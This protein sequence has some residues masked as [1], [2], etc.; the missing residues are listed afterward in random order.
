MSHIIPIWMEIEEERN[1]ELT[2]FKLYI[3]MG[4]NFHNISSVQYT[5]IV[6]DIII[7]DIITYGVSLSDISIYR[8]E[9]W[10]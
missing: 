9:H 6:T 8:R 1:G 3:Y 2:L 5:H 7:C 10:S 4:I